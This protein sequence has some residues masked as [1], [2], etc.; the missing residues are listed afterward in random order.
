MIELDGHEGS[1]LATCRHFRNILT[2]PVIRDDPVQRDL[3]LQSIV[4]YLLLAPYDNEQADL[5]H[6]VLE[7][8][9]MENVPHYKYNYLLF[10]SDI[11]LIFSNLSG[12][13]SSYSTHLS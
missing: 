10:L 2:T 9:L 4:L 5:T 6:R 3:I 13:S 8:P 7:D 12:V 1:F 11:Q